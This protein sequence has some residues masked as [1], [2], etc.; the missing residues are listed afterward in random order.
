MIEYV[1]AEEAALLPWAA[2]HISDSHRFRDDAKA[3]G[4]K[5]NGQ[6][7]AVAIYDSFS[8]NDCL[9]SIA[10]D[11]SRRWLTREFCIHVMAYPFIQCRL[12]RISCLV[13]RN[14][15]PSLRLTQRFGCW[16]LEGVLR[17]AGLGGEDLL[18]YGMLRRDCHYLPP[19]PTAAEAV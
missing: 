9:F 10:S 11:G 3:I 18:L 1:Y 14:N 13:S 2:A 6:L 12:T 4:V 16:E 15:Q 7:R 5:I 19:L 17:E 8:G